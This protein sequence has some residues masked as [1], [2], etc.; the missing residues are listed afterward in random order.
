MTLLYQTFCNPLSLYYI[1]SSQ[2]SSN[3]YTNKTKQTMRFL[4]GK[5]GNR[6]DNR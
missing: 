5:L 1:H 3:W 4:K 2:A 6:F